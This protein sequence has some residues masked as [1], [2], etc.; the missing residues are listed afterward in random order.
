MVRRKGNRIEWL[1]NKQ[2]EQIEDVEELKDLA[3]NFNRSLSTTYS[4][5]GGEFMRGCFPLLSEAMQNRL[6]FDFT[7][8]DT[9]RA[10]MKMGLL[11]APGPDGFQS[12]FF[13][14]IW[15]LIGQPLHN[16]AHDIIKE[17]NI[18]P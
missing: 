13:K 5:A 14:E 4:S 8:E 18:P 15:Q 12:V 3:L 7:K 2:G 17:G 11:K 9:K 10:V 6:A 16:F 1:A